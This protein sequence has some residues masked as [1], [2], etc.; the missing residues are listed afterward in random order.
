MLALF[1]K[2]KRYAQTVGA[3][4]VTTA[5]IVLVV[6]MK[7]VLSLSGGKDSLAL[8]LKVIEEKYPLDY[9]VFY[10]TGMEFQAIYSNIAKAE[11]LCKENSIQF[12]RLE[13]SRSFEYDMLHKPI[14]ARNG[15]EKTGRGWC[16]G[17]CRWGTAEKREAINKF[18]K[19]FD[20]EA[21]V[22]YVG[23]AAD[24]RQRINRDRQRNSVKLYPLIDW[25]MT[26]ADCL[27]YCY[28]KGWNWQEDG[29]ELYEVL[30]RVSCWCCKNKNKKELYNMFL[31]MPKYW[32][33]L[34]EL[35]SQ[36]SQPF[37][38]YGSIF[39]LENEFIAKNK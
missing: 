4:L 11:E 36:I 35:Q 20:G 31:Y 22:E 3:E 26:E 12:I 34:K 33:K 25:E 37:K 16:G 6:G 29:V 8:F 18:Y 7:Y 32:D 15:S 19:S 2:L 1:V 13:P 27:A 28:N 23:I 24:E 17:L 38:N 30:D 14:K 39:D 9:V 21:V 10:D 5:L